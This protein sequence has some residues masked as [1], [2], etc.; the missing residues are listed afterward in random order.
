MQGLRFVLEVLPLPLVRGSGLAAGCLRHFFHALALHFQPL[1][2]QV[3]HNSICSLSVS[4]RLITDLHSCTPLLREAPM[5]RLD[6]VAQ[7]ASLTGAKQ[8]PWPRA[9]NSW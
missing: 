1:R 6:G 2:V 3:L 7:H 8:R 5:D 9:A 4:I